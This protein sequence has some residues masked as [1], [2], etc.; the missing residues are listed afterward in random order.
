MTAERVAE[1]A[2]LAKIDLDPQADA[3]QASYKK[4]QRG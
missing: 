1:M 4:I 2:A 3:A